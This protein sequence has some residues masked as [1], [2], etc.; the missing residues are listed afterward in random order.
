MITVKFGFQLGLFLGA[1]FLGLACSARAWDKPLWV[2]QF[3]T[4]AY[5]GEFSSLAT[6]SAGNIYIVRNIGIF[7]DWWVFKYNSDGHVLWK[8]QLGANISWINGIGSDTSGNVYLAGL[9]GSDAWVAKYDTAGVLIWERQLGTDEYDSATDVATDTAGN[10]YVTGLTD[11]SFGGPNYGLGDAWVLKCDYAGNV[12]WKQQLGSEG[13]DL[14][15]GMAV[16]VFKNVYLVGRT[17]GALVVGGDRPLEDAWIAKYAP[18]GRFLWK[19]QYG[20][21]DYDEALDV[22]ADPAGDV[23]VAGTSGVNPWL[24]KY[25]AAGRLQWQ[26]R[27]LDL[28]GQAKGV[29]TD[30]AG[31]IYV[32]GGVLT[33]FRSYDVWLAKYD[34]A[35]RVQ[36][37][38]RLGTEGEEYP[39]DVATDDRGH[40]YLTGSTTGSLSG[41]N[42]GGTDAWM[43][44]YFT[45]R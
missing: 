9:T 41:S 14:S 43:A 40:V 13:T 6:D 21:A 44:K 42:L 31:G 7:Q 36:W 12:V 11:G 37:N 4:D 15:E 19:R 29:A 22:A 20:T 3:G 27:R 30:V 38:R 26:R 25:N 35:G 1:A 45:R 5:E 17:D 8:K 28:Y 32:T 24:A 10:V 2:R 18:T 33:E 39:S 34:T 23:Y 16:D